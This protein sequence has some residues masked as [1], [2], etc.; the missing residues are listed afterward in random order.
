LLSFG[1]CFQRIPDH[2]VIILSGFHCLPEKNYFKLVRVRRHDRLYLG[3]VFFLFE[4]K[5]LG[6]AK[7]EFR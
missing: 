4:V 5:K 7:H 1:L 3:K 2:K 6:E